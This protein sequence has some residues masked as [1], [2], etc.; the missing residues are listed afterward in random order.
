MEKQE[1]RTDVTTTGYAK[2]SN[3]YMGI[4]IMEKQDREE[5]QC[6]NNWL[7][8]W[9]NGYIPTGVSTLKLKL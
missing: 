3:G 1:K 7:C 8:K 6:N 4:S 2:W 5:N 9:S